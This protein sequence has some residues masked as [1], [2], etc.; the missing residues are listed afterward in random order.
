MVGALDELSPLPHATLSQASM[1]H[2]APNLAPAHPA[3]LTECPLT[4]LPGNR[5][6]MASICQAARR[7]P[8]ARGRDEATHQ[9]G[10]RQ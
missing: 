7:E 10:P 9:S 6:I 3:H 1:Q 5:D 8:T 4:T 2:D